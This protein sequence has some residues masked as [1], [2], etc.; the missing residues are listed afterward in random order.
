LSNLSFPPHSY[1]IALI[2]DSEAWN[3]VLWP[4]SMGGVLEAE[5]AAGQNALGLAL[6]PSVLVL[7][8]SGGTFASASDFIKANFGDGEADLVILEYGEEAFYYEIK[9]HPELEKG[10][11]SSVLPARIRDLAAQ[12]QKQG[13]KFAL[14]PIPRARDVSPTE[15]SA[16]GESRED[17]Q[18][19]DFAG[20]FHT[21][22]EFESSFADGSTHVIR[23]LSALVETDRLPEAPPLFNT[24]DNHLTSQASILIGRALAADL[25]AWKPWADTKAHL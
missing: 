19:F 4:E 22:L 18:A 7:S 13:T 23:V 24:F 14:L 25:R 6:H 16:A 1:R 3:A 17:V 9:L 21:G 2:G 20:N 10:R 11:G 5:L 15:N 12:L 8:A